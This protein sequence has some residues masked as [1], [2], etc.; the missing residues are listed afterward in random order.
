MGIG[1]EILLTN[2]LKIILEGRILA[3][4]LKGQSYAPISTSIKLG[5]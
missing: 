5:L 3:P 4:F 2:K 1:N